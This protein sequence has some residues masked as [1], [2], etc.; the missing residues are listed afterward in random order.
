MSQFVET[1]PLTFHAA[2]KELEHESFGFVQ[3]ARF[4]HDRSPVPACVLDLLAV[5]VVA[6][7]RIIDHGQQ[8]ADEDENLI[9]E[10]I[11]VDQIVAD[12]IMHRVWRWMERDKDTPIFHCADVFVECSP[13][14]GDDADFGTC[15][16]IRGHVLDAARVPHDG[17]VR[18]GLADALQQVHALT[19]SV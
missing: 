11:A 14:V 2:D 13:V 12:V 19:V 1:D 3:S 15:C 18:V 17:L 16:E 5:P 6:N 4:R 10:P 9:V 8:L 7:G